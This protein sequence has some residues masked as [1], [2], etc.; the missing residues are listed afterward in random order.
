ME[1]KEGEIRPIPAMVIGVWLVLLVIK[2]QWGLPINWFW[3][4][5][6]LWI[7]LGII[8]GVTIRNEF[9]GKKK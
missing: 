9:N 7:A 2:L 4:F 5:S 3:A 6:P 1:N 8:I